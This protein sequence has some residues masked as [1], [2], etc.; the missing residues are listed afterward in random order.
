[1]N[2]DYQELKYFDEENSRYIKVYRPILSI[3]LI[4]RGFKILTLESLL[5]SGADD[6][7]FPSFLARVFGLDY[8]R[9][10]I[11]DTNVAG[12]GFT[13]L[14]QMEYK[15]HGIDIFV[16]D[17]RIREKIFF[18]EGQRDIL[19]GQDFFKNFVIKFD[20]KNKKFHLN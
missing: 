11:I 14:Y 17:I 12:G 15:Q 1:M 13:D 19:L 4:K 2:C 10:K 3:N 6:I 5:D 7:I 18:S 9:A 16:N 20:R 8:K